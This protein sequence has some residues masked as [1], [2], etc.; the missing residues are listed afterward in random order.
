V[1]T[2]APLRTIARDVTDPV[3][4]EPRIVAH[5]CN[6]IGAWGAGVSGAIGR[7]WP[8]A[9]RM[10]RDWF[11]GRLTT[12]GGAPFPRPALGML[13]LVR[14]GGDLWV[15]NLIA[16]HG[17]RRAGDNGPRPLR[18]GAL[19][20]ALAKLAGSARER[21]ASVHCPRLGCGLAGGTWE[22][23]EPML[24]RTLLAAGIPVTVYDW[25]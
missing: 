6:D 17:V 10:Y 11:A 5:V 13:Q 12:E 7:R 25:G 3:G 2:P 20:N 9:E 19:E 23:I 22:E 8:K 4:I 24:Q 18:L 21:G 1:S 14:V 16:Q 15:A